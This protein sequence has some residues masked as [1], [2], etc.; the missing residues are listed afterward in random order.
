MFYKVVFINDQ[1]SSQYHTIDGT[2]TVVPI[3]SID[4]DFEKLALSGANSFDP[5]TAASMKGKKPSLGEVKRSIKVHFSPFIVHT[6]LIIFQSLVM[7]LM[8][9]TATMEALPRELTIQ[10][11]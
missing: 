9:A 7:R 11:T 10:T 1:R 4:E 3:M 6:V 2:N 8:H 5:I